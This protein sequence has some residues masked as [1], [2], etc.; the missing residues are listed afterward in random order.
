VKIGRGIRVWV[1][2][3]IVH[4][5]RLT[6]ME[7][8]VTGGVGPSFKFLFANGKGVSITVM[9]RRVMS[10]DQPDREVLSTCN[11]RSRVAGVETP[12]ND[13]QNRAED[14]EIPPGGRSAPF[15]AMLF[16]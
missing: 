7:V 16:L 5:N 10:I 6:Q 3:V 2:R 1:A 15:P 14:K 12:Y 9:V 11:L 13:R 4:S 8:S